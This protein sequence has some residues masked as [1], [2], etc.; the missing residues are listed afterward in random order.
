[1]SEERDPIYQKAAKENHIS[2]FDGMDSFHID[3][4]H[5]VSITIVVTNFYRNF[6]LS[7]HKS[8]E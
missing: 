4:E 3:K 8:Y 6:I 5:D 2:Q 7:T 1:M